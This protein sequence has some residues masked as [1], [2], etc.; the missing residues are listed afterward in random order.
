[1]VDKLVCWGKVTSNETH[2]T[3][4]EFVANV[5]PIG[6]L[7]E[8]AQL[9]QLLGSK[10]AEIARLRKVVDAVRAWIRAHNE[11]DIRAAHESM[12]DALTELDGEKA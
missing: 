7:L 3:P 11:R 5:P 6:S 12:I 4:E 10:D 9:R 8:S 2:V 1:M